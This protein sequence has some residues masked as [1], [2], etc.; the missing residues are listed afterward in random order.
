VACEGVSALFKFTVEGPST[1]TQTLSL[2]GNALD[3]TFICPDQEN[4]TAVVSV[5]NVHVACSTTEVR[6]N[7]VSCRT[8][9]V[10]NRD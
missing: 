1:Y 8:L 3:V 2:T 6:D 9:K 7:K 5:D 4:C 10:V